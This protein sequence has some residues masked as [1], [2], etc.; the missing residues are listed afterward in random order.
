[1]NIYNFNKKPYADLCATD[2]LLKNRSVAVRNAI[3]NKV[4]ALS[5]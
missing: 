3:C 1:M 5:T 2:F 4:R